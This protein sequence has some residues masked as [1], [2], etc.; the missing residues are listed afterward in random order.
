MNIVCSAVR[1]HGGAQLGQR[2]HLRVH[3][4]HG[5]HCQPPEEEV[6]QV[7]VEYFESIYWVIQILNFRRPMEQPVV[8]EDP[9][10]SLEL[11]KHCEDGTKTLYYHL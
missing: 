6:L 2:E 4:L 1:G 7:R 3:Q 11:F 10:K 9:R 8:D 5:G